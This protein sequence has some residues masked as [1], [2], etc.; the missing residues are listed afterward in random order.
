MLRY[1]ELT[2]E[3]REIVGVPNL[4]YTGTV[5]LVCVGVFAVVWV[6]L[7]ISFLVLGCMRSRS[8]RI[9]DDNLQD[10]KNQLCDKVRSP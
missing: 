1:G 3:A 10:P 6:G 8:P 2:N 9:F 4:E 7:Q 5:D